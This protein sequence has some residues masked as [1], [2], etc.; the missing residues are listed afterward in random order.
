MTLNNETRKV[1]DLEWTNSLHQYH[2]RS[3]CLGTKEVGS[4]WAVS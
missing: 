3:N 2:L 4:Q 1:L